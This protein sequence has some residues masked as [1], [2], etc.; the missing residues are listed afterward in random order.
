MD[1][2][3]HNISK[4]N[5]IANRYKLGDEF[6]RLILNTP[7]NHKD[8]AN[9]IKSYTFDRELMRRQTHILNTIDARIDL[10]LRG[11]AQNLSYFQKHG[12][13]FVA[14][15]AGDMV[16]WPV[17]FR[18]RSRKSSLDFEIQMEPEWHKNMLVEIN[19]SIQH[20]S[21]PE[22]IKNAFS[23]DNYDDPWRSTP[24]RVLLKDLEENVMYHVDALAEDIIPSKMND[25]NF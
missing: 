20:E 24:A 2:D 22:D 13:Y 18:D 10:M 19:L 11:D 12:V 15:H 3:S 7:V 4:I 5:P 1:R 6:D 17:M 23:T 25:F 21:T 14:Q 16:Y 9:T 8:W